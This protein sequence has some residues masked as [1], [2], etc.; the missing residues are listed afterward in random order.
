MQRL[1]R[2]ID[3]VDRVS[4]PQREIEIAV[5]R[6]R[7]CPRT[8]ERRA[9]DW[10]AVGR[11]RGGAGA[12]VGLDDARVEMEA[13]DPVV[14]DVA[15]EE[16]AVT[17]EDD[18][19]RL[20]ELRVRAGPA[21]AAE[22]GDAGARDGRDDAR[23]AIDPA[24]DVAVALG[25]EQVAARIEPDLVRH[26]QRGRRRRPAVAGV[27]PL[28]APRDR[29]H[30]PRGEIEP[31]DALIVEIAEVQRAVGPDDEAIW[32]VDRGVRVAGRTGPD[33]RPH[34]RR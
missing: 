22:P 15:D 32:I 29:R 31:A 19:V 30:A 20:A 21:V 34:G 7:H 1:R 12:G 24:D 11:R 18:A 14:A 5:R 4:L 25:D 13:P 3:P 10:R 27:P 33:E 8:V 28:A 6:E 23:R 17:I 2:R 9:A 16:R 26:V